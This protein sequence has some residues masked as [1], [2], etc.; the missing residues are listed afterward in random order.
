MALPDF[1]EPGI[2]LYYSIWLAALGLAAWRG[3]APERTGAGFVAATFLVQSIA[4][5]SVAPKFWEVD[6]VA[7]LADAIGFVAF[8]ALALNAK[9]IWPL[10]AAGLHLISLSAHFARQVEDDMVALAYATM[11]AVPTG[12]ALLL[13]IFGTLLHQRRLK[14]SGEDLP[15]ADF[16]LWREFWRAPSKHYIDEHRMAFSRSW[17]GAPVATCG[18][19]LI[20]YCISALTIPETPEI[21]VGTVTALSAMGVASIAGGLWLH[22]RETAQHMTETK[23]F[24]D[25]W[26]FGVPMLQSAA[27]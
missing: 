15:W 25:K 7:L 16:E 1:S 13:I 5:G 26:K 10:F 23:A 8:G 3:G 14:K 20:C 19:L 21:A 12:V 2:L 6:A 22:Q 18:L 9:R 27:G 4:Y 11:S 17:I 24:R